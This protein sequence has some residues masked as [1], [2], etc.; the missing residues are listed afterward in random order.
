MRF[1]KIL[2]SLLLLTVVALSMLGLE[3][4]LRNHTRTGAAVP[5]YDHI[6]V[7][8][9]ENHN[10]ETIIGNTAAPNINRLAQT[11]GL[12]TNYTAVADPSAPNYVALIGGSDYG[13]ADDNPYYTHTISNP[14]LV[15]QLEGAGLSWTAYLRGLPYPGYMGTCFPV[16]CGGT[17]DQD[18]LYASKHNGF[19]YFA[20]IQNSRAEQVHMVPGAQLEA[21]IASGNVPNFGFIVPDQCHDMHGS[22]PFCIDSANP[23]ATP[24]QILVNQADTYAGNLANEFLNAS[25]WTRGNNAFVITWDEGDTPQNRVVTI[26][27]TSHGPRGVKDGASYNHYSLLLTVEDSFGLSCLQHACD[28][29]VHPMTPLFA[30]S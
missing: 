18:A 22:P 14:S 23:G 27:I 7:L 25:W 17:P 10:F 11:Y 12:A 4:L 19:P 30:I 1:V 2:D 3:T 6:F 15:E 24:D 13:I 16:K 20:H 8:V 26:V 28:S 21:D 29:T 9:E 5:H